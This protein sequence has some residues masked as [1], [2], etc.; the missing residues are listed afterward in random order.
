MIPDF[1]SATGYLPPGVH[2]ANIT[3]VSKRFGNTVRRARLMVS[4]RNV[5]NQLWDA[6]VKEIFIDGSFCT[7]TPVPNDIDGY[8]VFVKGFDHTKVDPVLLQYDVF[9]TDPTSGLAVRPMKLRY[10][11]ELYVHPIQK[12]TMGGITYPEFFARSRDGVPR[13]YVRIVRDEGKGL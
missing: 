12:A 7:A 1:D 8:W 3:E 10:G 13:G 2:D 4:L 5:V 11:I 6:G 9:V